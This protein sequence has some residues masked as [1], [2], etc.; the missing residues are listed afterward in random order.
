MTTGAVPDGAFRHLAA[1][2]STRTRTKKDF[3]LHVAFVLL[4]MLLEYGAGDGE[5]TGDALDAA[6]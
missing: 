3:V 4:V 2:P 5:A 1:S 6:S